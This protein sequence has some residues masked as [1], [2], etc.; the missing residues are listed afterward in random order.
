MPFIIR[1]SAFF[2]PTFSKTVLPYGS[3]TQVSVC[4]SSNC[5][6]RERERKKEK[7]RDVCAAAAIFPR[8]WKRRTTDSPDGV[9]SGAEFTHTR[10]CEQTHDTRTDARAHIDRQQAVTWRGSRHTRPASRGQKFKPASESYCERM[11]LR[12]IHP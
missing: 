7:E 9:T 12:E 10:M 8:A 2:P 6:K 5:T 11:L 4:V 3:Y 1:P